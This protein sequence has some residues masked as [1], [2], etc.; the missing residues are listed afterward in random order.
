MTGESLLLRGGTIHVMDA[1]ETT[2]DA[3]RFRDGVVDALGDEIRENDGLEVDVVELDGR[4]VL[5]GFSDAHTHILAVGLAI[6]ET[7]LEAV[8]NRAETA[9]Y[10]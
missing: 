7:D 1:A 10:S 9:L 5:P 4:T 3:I 8:D 6:H 2:T